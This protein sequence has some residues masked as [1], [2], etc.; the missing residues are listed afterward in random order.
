IKQ[1]L[2]KNSDGTPLRNLHWDPTHDAAIILPTYGFNDVILQTNKA[3]QSGYTDQELAIG[4]AG[5]T[6]SGSR[7]AALASNPFRT[8]QRSTDSVNAE[9]EVWLKNL[10]GWASGTSSPKN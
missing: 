10:V 6:S 5:Y 4:I 9:M 8:K 1:S 7:Y 2:S 3:M